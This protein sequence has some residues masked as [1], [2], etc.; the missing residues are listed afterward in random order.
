[1]ITNFA[2]IIGSMKSG[3]T[4]LFHYLSQHPEIS[5][6]KLKELHFFSNIESYSKGFEYYQK[7]WDWEETQKIALEASTSYTMQPT[8]PNIAEKIQRFNL[9]NVRFI[10]LIRNPFE[11]IESHIRH[12]ISGGHLDKPKITQECIEF[13]KY[14]SQLDCY[15]KA[16]GK[17]K[18]H[19]VLL[20]DLKSDP[21]TVLEIACDFLDIDS[22][23]KFFDTNVVM[24]SNKTLNLHPVVR[25][26]Y[27]KKYVRKMVSNFISP[28]IRQRL[29]KPLSRKEEISVRLDQKDK[30]IILTQI[31]SDLQR[32]ETEYNIDVSKK[33][34]ININSIRK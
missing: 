14:A 24:N 21:Q 23:W 5:P 19:I 17:D 29:Y 9:T 3:T 25:N 1:M 32:L 26:L 2:I 28:S 8:Y 4:S 20:E 10:Y 12:L 31:A 16:F 13:T 22:Q 33:W 7:M 6:S 11:R 30:D 15:V 18:I 34:Q 27:R